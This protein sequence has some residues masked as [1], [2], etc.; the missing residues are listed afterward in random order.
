MTMTIAASR[1][2]DHEIA[3][4]QVAEGGLPAEGSDDWKLAWLVRWAVLAPSGN[5]A[6]PWVFRIED[7]RIAERGT[8]DQLLARGGRYAEL[9]ERQFGSQTGA[10]NVVAA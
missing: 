9:Y 2:A 6:Q 4:W 10:A 1:S 3:P 5:N 8:H 7:G